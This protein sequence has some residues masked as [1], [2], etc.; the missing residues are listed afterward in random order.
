MS[1]LS[2]SLVVALAFA[3]VCLAPLAAR[4]GASNPAG[5]VIDPWWV[6]PNSAYGAVDPTRYSSDSN[7][8]IGCMTTGNGFLSCDARSID[9][10]PRSCSGYTADPG[11]LAA[12][13]S[14]NKTSL[15]QFTADATDGSCIDLRVTNSSLYLQ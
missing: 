7:Q 6:G 8:S 12:A 15:I 13:R 4:A 3:A 1:R 14:I 5:V 2:I 9:G 11:L 10:Y